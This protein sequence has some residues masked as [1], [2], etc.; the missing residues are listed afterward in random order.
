MM[1]DGAID[2]ARTLDALAARVRAGA[3]EEAAPWGAVTVRPV[4]D[5]LPGTHGLDP[6]VRARIEKKLAAAADRPPH[7]GFSLRGSRRPP[8]YGARDL[9]PGTTVD[10]RL[11]TIDGTHRI[12]VFVVRPDDVRPGRPVLVYFHGGGFSTCGFAWQEPQMRAIAARSGCTVVYPEYRLAPECPF[13]GPVRDAW[14]TV[15]W[16]FEHAGELGVDPGRIVVGGDSAGGSLANACAL[17]D[18]GGIIHRL[19]EVYPSFDWRAYEEQA[20]Y[21]W[22]MD[23][24]DVDSEEFH[25]VEAR[26]L[27]VKRCR[28]RREGTPVDLYFQGGDVSDPLASAICASDGAL[29]AFPPMTM[30]FAEYDYLRVVGE[31]AAK[32]LAALGVSVDAYLYEG[33]DHGFFDK[34]SQ[35]AQSR[36]LAWTIGD[37]LA[38]ACRD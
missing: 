36:E 3:H 15:R 18:Q 21:A 32:R 2:T 19:V 31:A 29:A 26:I 16:V 28:E 6:R 1:D 5:A 20:D 22:S 24:Y 33:V 10:E 35:F 7:A 4:P 27:G 23:M 30:M 13:P 14:G 9:A 17:L 38:G 11:V 34:W 25:L 12:D 8:V 37:V